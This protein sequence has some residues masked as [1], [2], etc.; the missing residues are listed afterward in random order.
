MRFVIF[1]KITSKSEREKEGEKQLKEKLLLC[2]VNF[3]FFVHGLVVVQQYKIQQQHTKKIENVKHGEQKYWNWKYVSNKSTNFI[4]E[5]INN[6][7]FH[8][9]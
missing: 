8:I 3:P 5:M 1:Q 2:S 9:A 6:Q 4:V 7:Q